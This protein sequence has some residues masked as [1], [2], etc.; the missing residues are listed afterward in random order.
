MPLCGTNCCSGASSA[1]SLGQLRQP[2]KRASAA[3]SMQCEGC[4]NHMADAVHCAMQQHTGPVYFFAELPLAGGSFFW[5]ARGMQFSAGSIVNLQL[6][7]PSWLCLDVSIRWRCAHF[8]AVFVA[9]HRNCLTGLIL[10]QNGLLVKRSL[11]NAP[12]KPHG[13]CHC[14]E[15][16][17]NT[18]RTILLMSC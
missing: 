11:D 12:A 9:Q 4:W 6:K 18:A 16:P 13:G 1:T 3:S 17:S 7:G 14:S 2:H 8:A 15:F 5:E 10:D